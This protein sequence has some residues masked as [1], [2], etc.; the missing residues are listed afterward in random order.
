[1]KK[2]RDN[3][4]RGRGLGRAGFTLL[5]LVVALMMVAVL[6]L[7]LYA[8]IRIAFKA[9]NAAESAIEPSRTAELAM[10]FIR[11]DIQ[12]TL[13]PHNPDQYSSQFQYL[14]GAFQGQN[15][16]GASGADGDLNFF[17]TADMKQHVSGNGEIKQIELT[18][19]VPQGS[20]QK[21]LVRKCS[22]NL[23]V[24]QQPPPYDE[25]ILVRGIESF[26]LRFFDGTDWQDTWDSTDQNG[27][28]PNPNELPAA[29]EVT[30]VVD[31]SSDPGV[32]DV[33]KFIRVFQLAC[34]NAVVD[35]ES[36]TTGTTP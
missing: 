19:E 34:S 5:E 22:R 16:G 33:V 36:S 26:N 12:N 31:K 20:S 8:T 29:V 32:K 13:A 15:S 7:S 9:Q 14:A 17:S 21:C 28:L 10:G 25:E 24:E 1:M 23:T 18:T 4:L 30:L 11:Q 2:G 3:N 27:D 6:A 35:S